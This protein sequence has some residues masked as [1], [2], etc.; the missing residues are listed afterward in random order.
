MY[1]IING[2]DVIKNS[3][4]QMKREGELRLCF[5]FDRIE[6]LIHLGVMRYLPPQSDLCD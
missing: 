3:S 1:I 4:L 2:Q 6:W 5:R